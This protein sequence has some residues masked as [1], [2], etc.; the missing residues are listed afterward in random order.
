M[1]PLAPLGISI[2]R[3]S[4]QSIDAAYAVAHAMGCEWV[5]QTLIT[6]YVRPDSP[7]EA[8][9]YTIVD[10]LAARAA[11]EGLKVMLMC[12]QAPWPFGT[13]AGGD[14]SS[15]GWYTAYPGTSGTDRWGGASPGAV[16]GSS[17]TE[18]TVSYGI[19]AYSSAAVDA[20]GSY[21]RFRIPTSAVPAWAE[22]WNLAVARYVATYV[23]AGGRAE[24]VILELSNESAGP[25]LYDDHWVETHNLLMAEIEVPEGAR[26]AM[27]SSY[28]HYNQ[29]RASLERAA[30][31]RFWDDVAARVDVSR[32]DLVNLH[33][34]LFF[35]DS[36]P[37]P[38]A[39]GY[40]R[41]LVRRVAD[42][43]RYIQS[44]PAFAGK[45]V[46]LSEIGVSKGALGIDQELVR[47]RVLGR[48]LQAVRRLPFGA[49]A[50]WSA[51]TDDGIWSMIN[52]SNLPVGQLAE[53]YRALG[54]PVY[55]NNQREPAT[56]E[57]YEV[58]PTETQP[59][60]D[61]A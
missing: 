11:A 2:A 46:I 17:G 13:A 23:A 61:E 5:R 7:V 10:E 55:N 42:T 49:V 43:L 29:G 31:R 19:A 35:A 39:S 9:D 33:A 45:G 16:T 8:P 6:C 54:K 58:G 44:L 56:D 27:D 24:D 51:N 1:P 59:A 37:G 26:L 21:Y 53:V 25:G 28:G 60:A 36:K 47:G 14:L 38:G 57:A 48:V 30:H 40:E 3:R 20:F 41:A 15:W 32:Y 34:Y 12:G 22:L 4:A 18:G 52:D 50:L